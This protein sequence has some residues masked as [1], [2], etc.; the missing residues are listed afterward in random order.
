LHHQ[1]EALE[2]WVADRRNEIEGHASRLVAQEIELSRRQ[3][4]LEELN[5]R[6]QSER[7]LYEGEI[8]RLLGELRRGGVTAASAAA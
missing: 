8:R 3:T 4:E 5:E 7:R 6:Q 1:K 2:Q